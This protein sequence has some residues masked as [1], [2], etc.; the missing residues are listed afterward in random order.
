MQDIEREAIEEEGT[1]HQSF[2]TVC[3][4][5]LQACPPEACGILMYPL[6]LLTGNMSLAALL[7][8]SPQPSTNMGKPNPAT[9]YPTASAA[10]MP[11]SGTKQQC[12]PPNQEVTS[13]WSVD[14]E[15]TWTSEQLPHQ[16][17]KNRKPLAKLLKG[18]W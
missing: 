13:P 3:G 17:Q 1:D 18:G 12:P 10:L 9:P 14:E 5:A 15:A 6:Q 8:I 2:L 4:V 11:T 16:K 7:A